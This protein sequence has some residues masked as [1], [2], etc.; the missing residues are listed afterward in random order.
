MKTQLTVLRHH[1]LTWIGLA[2]SLLL[3]GIAAIFELDPADLLMDLLKSTEEYELDEFFLAILIFL[4]F[5]A[6]DLFQRQKQLKIEEEK[7][8]VYTAMLSSAHHILNNF[9]NQMQLVKITA[10]N[11]PGFDPR[12]LDLYDSI[13][14][15][16]EQQMHKLSN[17]TEITEETIKESVKPQ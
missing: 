14:N 16:A 9:L 13:M 2:V 4:C 11:T 10:D 12:V 8:I 17:L 3:F 15:D 7:I 1:K 6:V 5:L